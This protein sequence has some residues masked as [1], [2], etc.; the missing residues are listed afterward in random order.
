MIIFYIQIKGN[1]KGCFTW[2]LWND[3]DIKLKLF[4]TCGS[5]KSNAIEGYMRYLELAPEGKHVNWYRILSMN[6]FSKLKYKK[7]R[8]NFVNVIDVVKQQL[9]KLRE[10]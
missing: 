7:D 6:N 4:D 1:F 8:K 3:P 5:N 2:G 9:K 10:L